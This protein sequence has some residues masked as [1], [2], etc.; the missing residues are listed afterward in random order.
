MCK[1]TRTKDHTICDIELGNNPRKQ[2]IK[3]FRSYVDLK[4]NR[5]TLVANFSFIAVEGDWP[6]C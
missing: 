2:I 5:L 4:F 3:I 6:D 1:Q